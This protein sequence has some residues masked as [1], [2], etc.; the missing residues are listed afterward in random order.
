[1]KIY[2]YTIKKPPAKVNENLGYDLK[3]DCPNLNDTIRIEAIQ[4]RFLGRV[5]IFFGQDNLSTLV[6]EGVIKHPLENF[7]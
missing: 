5:D 2:G 3:T 6:F 1:M 4:N 7:G